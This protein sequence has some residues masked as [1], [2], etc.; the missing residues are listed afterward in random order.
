MS[1][2]FSPWI[3]V[4]EPWADAAAY[5]NSRRGTGLSCAAVARCGMDEPVMNEPFDGTHRAAGSVGDGTQLFIGAL[6]QPGME[7]ISRPVPP[8]LAQAET[9]E[10]LVAM[11]ELASFGIVLL[12]HERTVRYVNG[13]ARALLD[14]ASVLTCRAGKLQAVVPAHR[15]LL[16][17][18]LAETTGPASQERSCPSGKVLKLNVAGCEE[19]LLLRSYL[20]DIGGA[21]GRKNGVAL[22]LF[23]GRAEESQRQRTL[24]QMFGLS[25]AESRIAELLARGDDLGR[26]AAAV[27]IEKNTVRAHL[28]SLFAKTNTRRQAQLVALLNRRLLALEA[29]LKPD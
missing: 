10:C 16:D 25:S 1:R 23:D 13:Q 26:I 27:K 8:G 6:F 11:G 12:G 19:C 17:G 24:R 5:A 2:D 14:E 28:R 22:F 15:G 21:H 29:L 20:L 3:A 4:G 7:P 18:L 9:L